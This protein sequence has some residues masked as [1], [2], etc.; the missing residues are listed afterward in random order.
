MNAT[1][2]AMALESLRLQRDF[3][4]RQQDLVRVKHS[5][6]EKYRRALELQKQKSTEVLEKM[7]NDRI[8]NS[9]QIQFAIYKTMEDT[10]AL[11]DSLASVRPKPVQGDLTDA[12][13]GSM[14]DVVDSTTTDEKL[15]DDSST[16]TQ[17]NHSV[18]IDELRT[19]NHSLHILVYRLV[20]QLDESSQ[21]SESLRE[22][23]KFL[24]RERRAVQAV[25]QAQQ[26]NRVP[27]SSSFVE[28]LNILTDSAEALDIAVPLVG[29]TLATGSGTATTPTTNAVLDLLPP[30]EM[31]EFNFDSFGISETSKDLISSADLRE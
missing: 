29:T 10:D 15:E 28:Q 26:K 17:K 9:S 23:V 21:E 24:E 31:P 13:N 4:L 22:K 8:E 14:E 25:V 11:L 18:M 30:L 1:T 7:A 5:Q 3:H 27:I 2:V 6:F 12:D 19:L 20:T 16:G